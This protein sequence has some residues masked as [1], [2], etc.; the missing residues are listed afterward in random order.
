MN[1]IML[2]T[3]NDIKVSLKINPSAEKIFKE[4]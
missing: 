4:R 2:N 1:T 3:A